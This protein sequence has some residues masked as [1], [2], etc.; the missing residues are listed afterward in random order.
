M[1]TGHIECYVAPFSVPFRA[2]R[3]AWRLAV[4]SRRNAS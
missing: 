2:R 3:D 4:A 1:S